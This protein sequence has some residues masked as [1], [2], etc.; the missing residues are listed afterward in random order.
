M[1]VSVGCVLVALGLAFGASQADGAISN[2]KT[3]G[4]VGGTWYQSITR[5]W[6]GNG[7]SNPSATAISATLGIY[8]GAGG[9]GHTTKTVGA[10]QTWTRLFDFAGQPYGSSWHG[11][12]ACSS[13]H[14]RSVGTCFGLYS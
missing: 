5:W 4:Y 3:G 8:F 1:R 10:G 13:A 9:G 12:N 6:E 7:I 11:H 14:T 2:Y